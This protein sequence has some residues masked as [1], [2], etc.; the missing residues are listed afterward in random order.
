MRF[1][2]TKYIPRHWFVNFETSINPL[3]SLCLDLIDNSSEHLYQEDPRIFSS[4]L[5][6]RDHFY[7]F[8]NNRKN[9]L[10]QI[11]ESLRFDYKNIEI[12]IER[13]STITILA[14]TFDELCNRLQEIFTQSDL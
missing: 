14:L 2:I 7:A 11:L 4:L 3:T 10:Q 8:I 1:S 9:G 6:S 12:Q 13:H 5:N